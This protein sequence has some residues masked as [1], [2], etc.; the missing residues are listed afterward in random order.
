M[1][2]FV[3]LV[4]PADIAAHLAE[5]EQEIMRIDR[6]LRCEP[7]GKLHF[8]LEFLGEKT[9]SWIDAC[10]A[11]LGPV[12]AAHAPFAV[13][14]KGIGFF[15][16]TARPRIIWAGSAP[17]DNRELCALASAVRQAC[18]AIGH[19]PDAK[20]FHPHITLS[21]VKSFIQPEKIQRIQ[22]IDVK[23][24]EFECREIVLMK[25]TLG[26]GGSKYE[27]LFAV[28]LGEA[29]NDPRASVVVSASPHMK[30]ILH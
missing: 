26:A 14:F 8:T 15:P 13:A 1:R 4:P 3:A 25:S 21:R 23:P 9:E 17:E 22:A 5:I 29:V 16:G 28:K 20:P 6:S 30:R 7:A 2:T 19:V 11:A 18:A 27:R 10:R 12:V 24:L